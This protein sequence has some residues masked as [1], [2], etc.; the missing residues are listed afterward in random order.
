MKTN[1]DG[2]ITTFTQNGDNSDYKEYLKWVDEG[3]KAE[4]VTLTIKDAD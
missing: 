1:S 4:E 3:N 2:S